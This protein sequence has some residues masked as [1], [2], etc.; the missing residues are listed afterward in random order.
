MVILVIY[1]CAPLFANI[2]R[3]TY[4]QIPP[5]FS[6][7]LKPDLL[8]FCFSSEFYRVSMTCVD[9]TFVVSLSFHDLVVHVGLLRCFVEIVCV[10]LHLVLS[11]QKLS[12]FSILCTSA[13]PG[14]I[15]PHVF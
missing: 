3:A 10:K 5:M 8:H 15:L 6:E 7:L 1:R 13:E 4:L 11:K 12:M 14:C 9:V 2:Q